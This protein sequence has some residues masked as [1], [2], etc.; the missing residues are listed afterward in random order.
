MERWGESDIRGSCVP[1]DDRLT[2]VVVAAADATLYH[3]VRSLTISFL[4]SVGVS[5]I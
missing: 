5:E 1:L 3:F 2:V 4:W